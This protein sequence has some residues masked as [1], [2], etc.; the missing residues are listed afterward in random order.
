MIF[1]K[2]IKWKQ[3]WSLVALHASII[4]GWIAY[5]N[6][7]PKLL[8]QYNYQDYGFFLVIAQAII[9]FITPPVAGWLGDRYRKRSGH[10][11]P[12]IAMGISF[13]AM[14]FMT[15]A[16]TLIIN[17]PEA[18][19]FLLPVLI[20]LW[21]ISMSIFT[22]PAL[23]TSELFAPS[24]KLPTV[25][26]IL[27][28]VSGLLYSIEPI[29]VD[30]IDFWGAPFTFFAGGALVFV[31]GYYLRNSITNS[32]ITD[33]VPENT[34]DDS[35]I[36]SYVRIFFVGLAFG[37]VTAVIFNILPDKIGDKFTNLLN[38]GWQ[39]KAWVSVFL[40]LSAILCIPISAWVE[41]TGLQKSLR[42]GLIFSLLLIST[43]LS[44]SNTSTLLILLFMF[45]AAYSVLSVS[46]LPMA[47]TR[48]GLTH[49]VLAIGIFFSGVELPN[50]IIDALMY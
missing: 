30:I 28:I 49:K 35:G 4:I 11:L 47:L 43:I 46:A 44:T 3:L 17:P 39:G 6:Y 2:D 22:S 21:L 34:V 50:S 5:Y 7:Q 12:I 37:L 1:S 20:I 18:F 9:L 23:S 42:I 45:A 40:A 10:R 13:A 41:K 16:F 24:G 25:V 31:S 33:T 19:L 32:T 14:I 8:A 27:S 26:A 38:L 36:M 15:V 48:S 29:I